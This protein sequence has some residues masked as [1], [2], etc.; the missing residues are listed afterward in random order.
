MTDSSW[1]SSLYRSPDQRELI[2]DLIGLAKAYCRG[3]GRPSLNRGVFGRTRTGLVLDQ[4]GV[5]YELRE[6]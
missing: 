2:R 5:A 4:A 1:T 6:G 3:E